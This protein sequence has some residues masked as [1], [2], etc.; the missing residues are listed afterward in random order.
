MPGHH[1]N[2]KRLTDFLVILTGRLLRVVQ[3]LQTAST[4]SHYED[5]SESKRIKRFTP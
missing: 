2:C 1:A 4:L 5:T 3:H